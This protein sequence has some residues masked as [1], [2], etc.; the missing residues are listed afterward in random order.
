MPAAWRLTPLNHSMLNEC[1]VAT[2]NEYSQIS[3]VGVIR[4]FIFISSKYFVL[5]L[6]NLIKWKI[7]H[8][9]IISSAKKI[10]A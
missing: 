9:E 4:R 3:V 8:F 10:S 2:G 7:L 1:G 5:V 6:C